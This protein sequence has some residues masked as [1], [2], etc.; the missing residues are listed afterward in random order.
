MMDSAHLERGKVNN[1]V[2]VGVRCK[3]LVEFTFV[4]DVGL[5]E[6]GSLSA[7]EL[8]AIEGDFGRV[9]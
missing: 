3:D 4:G 6:L 5:E 2:D 8:N 1:T 9:V 7:D